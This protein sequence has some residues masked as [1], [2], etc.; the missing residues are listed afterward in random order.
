MCLQDCPLARFPDATRLTMS[1]T[2]YLLTEEPYYQP[3]DSE[4]AVY[5]SALLPALAADVQR[6]NRLRQDTFRR[7]HSMAPE[8]PFDHARL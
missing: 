1:I 5:E 4:I 8:T 6:P 2:R 7:A 3:V